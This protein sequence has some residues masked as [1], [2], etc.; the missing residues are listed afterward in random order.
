MT[1]GGTTIPRL[2]AELTR[3]LCFLADSRI[4]EDEVLRERAGGQ[5][6]VP[7]AGPVRLRQLR[8]P[9]PPDEEPEEARDQRVR[10]TADAPV[11]VL[12][13]QSDLQ[14]LPAGAHDETRAAGLHAADHAHQAAPKPLGMNSVIP[15]MTG[16]TA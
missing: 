7:R 10:Q 3:T 15:L 12:P 11:R 9:L 6:E 2:A 4:R 14:V 13:V 16:D 8:P 5:E 1:A